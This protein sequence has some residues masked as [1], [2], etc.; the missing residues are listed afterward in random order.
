MAWR[1]SSVPTDK[2][3]I[4]RSR[5]SLRVVSRNR[6]VGSPSAANSVAGL[7]PRAATSAFDMSLDVSDLF[8]PATLVH[9]EGFGAAMGGDILKAGLGHRQ[10]RAGGRRF[11]PKLDERR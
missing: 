7:S 1:V 10:A 3:A 11:Q 2:P 5:P 4:D 6:R 8:G 9:A